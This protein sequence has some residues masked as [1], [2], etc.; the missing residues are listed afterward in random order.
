VNLMLTFTDFEYYRDVFKGGLSE[1]QYSKFVNDAHAEIVSQT[2]N[3]A[4]HAPDS[5]KDAVKL[6]ECALVDAL[7]DHKKSSAMLPDDISSVSNDDLKVSRSGADPKK[8]R[9]QELRSICVRYLQTPVN[10]MCR[11]A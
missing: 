10:L 5:M 2:N 8:A 4:A 3:R 1:D 6:C 9:R 11:W 7:A